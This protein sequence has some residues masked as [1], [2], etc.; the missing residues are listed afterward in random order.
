MGISSIHDSPAM[1]AALA[2]AMSPGKVSEISS[3]TAFSGATSHTS[4]KA[5]G[6]PFVVV[7]GAVVA[8][9]RV[10]TQSCSPAALV[11]GFNT[12]SIHSSVGGDASRI[13]SRIVFSASDHGFFSALMSR[14]KAFRT[15]TT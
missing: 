2:A 9:L 3:S 10:M 5:S 8:L 4:S 6:V 15:S 13:P 14:L 7:T 1:A 12:T 11:N